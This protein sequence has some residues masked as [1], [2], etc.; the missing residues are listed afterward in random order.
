MM[1]CCS[2]DLPCGVVLV[3]AI[4]ECI[5]NVWEASLKLEPRH[6]VRGSIQ[7]NVEDATGI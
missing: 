6:R 7:G 2:G 1:L 5:E 4:D 3:L